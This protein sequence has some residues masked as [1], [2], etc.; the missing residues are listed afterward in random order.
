MESFCWITMQLPVFQFKL[1][2]PPLSRLQCFHAYVP[3]VS[4][5]CSRRE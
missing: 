2:T 1:K 5:L 4:T 3:Q